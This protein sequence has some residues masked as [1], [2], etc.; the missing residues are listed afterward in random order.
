MKNVNKTN[1]RT[2]TTGL[3]ILQQKAQPLTDLTE[4][5]LMM[6]ET[7]ARLAQEQIAPY[8]REMDD[9]GKLKESIVNSLFENG[10]S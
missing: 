9:S 6:K 8:V 7:V 1:I 5:E 2:I 4:D 10:V 3:N